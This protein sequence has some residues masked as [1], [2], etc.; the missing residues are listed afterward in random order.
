[1]PTGAV[2]LAATLF[3]AG[4]MV[5]LAGAATAVVNAVHSKVQSRIVFIGRI[6][7]QPVF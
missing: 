4:V 2:T 6:L 3:A 1:M 5:E 7:S